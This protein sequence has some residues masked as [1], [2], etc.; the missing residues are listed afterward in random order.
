MVTGAEAAAEIA[1]AKEAELQAALDAVNEERVA[2]K[3]Q[4]KSLNKSLIDVKDALELETKEKT[5]LEVGC[6][7]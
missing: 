7:S 2:L 1:A 3:E 4:V 6:Q 5:L